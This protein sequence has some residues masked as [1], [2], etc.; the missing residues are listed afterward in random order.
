MNSAET[1]R[2]YPAAVEAIAGQS[3]PIPVVAIDNR[4]TPLPFLSYWAIVDVVESVLSQ[5]RQAV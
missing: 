4:L 3:L 2:D 5:Q 1:R